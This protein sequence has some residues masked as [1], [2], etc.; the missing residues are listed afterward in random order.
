MAPRRKIPLA[1]VNPAVRT[2]AALLGPRGRIAGH[3]TKVRSARAK[4]S[5]CPR[6]IVWQLRR[7][8]R[9]RRLLLRRSRWLWQQCVL[10]RTLLHEAHV[11]RPAAT[12]GCYALCQ[13]AREGRAAEIRR[14][15]IVRQPVVQR[16]VPCAQARCLCCTRQW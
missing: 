1:D 2:S 5:W 3:C 4:G 6:G 12:D 13:C 7:S 10:I 16:N 9:Q 14:L 8:C 11:H 15:Q